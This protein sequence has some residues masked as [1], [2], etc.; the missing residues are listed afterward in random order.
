MQNKQQ[1]W[2]FS[3]FCDWV[4]GDW[5]L[6]WRQSEEYN[7][8]EGTE[9]RAASLLLQK[10]T[11]EAVWAFDEDAPGHLLAE[12]FW[13]CLTGKHWRP[14]CTWW[15]DYTSLVSWECLGVPLDEHCLGCCFPAKV[16]AGWTI[17]TERNFNC[18]LIHNV[19]SSSFTCDICCSVSFLKSS[20]T[21]D[22]QFH[23]SLSKFMQSWYEASTV[24]IV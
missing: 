2:A 5:P 1:K 6:P 14:W 21:M 3:H 19:L 18:S 11:I 16:M 8:S 9:S 12:V 23:S 17:L 15:R 24:F 7:D 20:F 10:E 4:K 22:N 13:A